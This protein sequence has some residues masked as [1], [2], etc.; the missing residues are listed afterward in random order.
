MTQVFLYRNVTSFP[1]PGNWNP[2]NNKVECIGAGGNGSAAWNP[3][4]PNGGPNV[5]FGGGGG[6]YAW[7]VNLNP[8][9]PVPTGI[10][11][12][13]VGI[14]S[15]TN[16]GSAAIWPNINALVSAQCGNSGQGMGGGGQGGSAGTPNG[17]AGGSGGSMGGTGNGSGG[18]G[19]GGPLGAGTAGV[20]GGAG[21]AA[22]SGTIPGGSQGQHGVS[23]TNWDAIHGIGSGG[24]GGITS[25]ANGGAA[26]SFGGGAGSQAGNN[27]PQASTAGSNG[28]IVIT[29]AQPRTTTE[30]FLHNGVVS[31]PNPGN[32]NPASNKVECVGMGGVGAPGLVGS[33]SASGPGGGGGGY[34]WAVNLGPTFPVTVNVPAYEPQP[35]FPAG[36]CFWNGTASSPGNVSAAFGFA[37]SNAISGGSSLGGGGGSAYPN[38]SVGGTGGNGVTQDQ[39]QGA[40]GGGGGAGPHGNGLVGVAGSGNTS[41]AGGAGDAG[42]TP[43]PTSAGQMVTGT[44]WDNIYGI[45]SG[46]YAASGVVGNAGN[47]G[48]GGAGGYGYNE[49]SSPSGAGGSPLMV[50]TYT[51]LV[52]AAPQ[53]QVQIMA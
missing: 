6:A 52:A 16:F 41:G 31:F 2:A 34:G 13:I 44:Q 11:G 12:P 14:N 24:G 49:A 43:A 8:I 42:N 23:G 21:G 48:G 46:G 40:G 5:G 10:T 27:T 37:G 35:G 32:W 33:F 45:G 1:D 51:P 18:G 19:A 25:G 53:G 28:L 38:P 20:T 4:P 39:G 7:A 36:T 26:G 50:I 30:I 17:F 9:F 22:D 29:Y 15:G 3:M 47:F